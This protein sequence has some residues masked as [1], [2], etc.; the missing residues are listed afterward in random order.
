M[1]VVMCCLLNFS[2]YGIS[3][4]RWMMNTKTKADT[5]NEKGLQRS[6]HFEDGYNSGW[7]DGIF[8]LLSFDRFYF[9][10]NSV[11]DLVQFDINFREK[12]CN[13]IAERTRWIE[14][15]LRKSKI[16]VQQLFHPNWL[17]SKQKNR[18][19]TS[20][21]V[22]KAIVNFNL[23]PESLSGRNQMNERRK[24][25]QHPQDSELFI[26]LWI[27]QTGTLSD[28]FSAQMQ[29]KIFDSLQ[30]KDAGIWK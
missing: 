18:L 13:F 10:L 25:D 29:T 6:W 14:F 27:L 4:V 8:F 12:I 1:C 26:Y 30:K 19:I 28:K 16:C 23:I 21:C 9:T 22:L 7:F 17:T 11:F 2:F 3:F 5:T 24:R 20:K 15:L